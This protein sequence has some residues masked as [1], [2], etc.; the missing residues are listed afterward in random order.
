M[1]RPKKQT[2]D[3]FPHDCQHKGTMFILEE[4][5][6]NDGYAFWFKML[7][8]LGT[9]EGHFIDCNNPHKWLFLTSK[10][11]L[12]EDKCTEL[13]NLLASLDAIDKELWE[14][15]KTIWSDNF[16][17][18]I[19]E[20]YRN[21]IL[22]IPIKP[23]FLHK[24]SISVEGFQCQSDVRNPQ[25]KR[26]ET[27]LNNIVYPDWLPL[28]AFNDFKGMRKQIKKPLTGKA[29]ELIIKELLRLKESG[30]DPKTVLEKSIM[31][32]WQGVFELGTERNKGETL[33]AKYKPL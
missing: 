15:S 9:T 16:V 20:A 32:S 30:N 17:E 12:T 25:S 26:K 2:V 11:R 23:S 29:E 6:G 14:A 4:K 27:K 7:E 31:N 8:V 21:R 33:S 22:E 1:A 10:T 18:R 5:Y 28:E 13:L 3:Y 24:K 19:S